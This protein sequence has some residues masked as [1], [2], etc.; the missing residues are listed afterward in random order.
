MT[1]RVRLAGAI[2]LAVAAFAAEPAAAAQNLG[3]PIELGPVGT[4]ELVV[5]DLDDDGA[6]DV[7]HAGDPLTTWYGDGAGA[8]AEETHDLD[9]GLYL[10][11]T[12]ADL[13]EDGFGD[14]LTTQIL[15]SGTP[16]TN[17]FKLLSDGA[18]GLEAGMSIPGTARMLNLATG[19]F[20]GDGHTDVAGPTMAGGPI[21]VLLGDGAGGFDAGADYASVKPAGGIAAADLDGNGRDDLIMAQPDGVAVLRAR[22]GPLA[23]RPSGGLDLFLP[24]VL[25]S[26]AG[27]RQLALGDFDADGKLD[28]AATAFNGLYLLF[29]DGLGGLA[30]GQA[31]PVGFIGTVS[32]VATGDFG[33]DGSSDLAVVGDGSDLPEESPAVVSLILGRADRQP[34]SAGVYDAGLDGGGTA[35]LA[36]GDLDEDGEEDVVVS[37]SQGTNI[38]YG[39]PIRMTPGLTLFEDT[40]VDAISPVYTVT[41]SNRDDTAHAIAGVGIDGDDAGQF[42]IASETCTGQTLAPGASC[43]IGVRFTPDAPVDA[44]AAL[45]VDSDAP[46]PHVALLAG[47]AFEAPALDVTP[48]SLSFGTVSPGAV[49]A[50]RTVTATNEGD[51]E[52]VIT[53]GGLFGS[54]YFVMADQDCYPVVLEPGDSCSVTLRFRPGDFGPAAGSLRFTGTAANTPITVP[55]SGSTPSRPPNGG[56]IVTP[57]ELDFGRVALGAGV[58]RDVVL[59]NGGVA[60]LTLG[61]LMVEPYFSGFSAQQAGCNAFVVGLSPSC[62]VTVRFAPSHEGGHQANVFFRSPG[63][64]QVGRFTVKGIGFAPA[65]PPPVQEKQPLAARVRAGIAGWRDRGVEG[66]VKRGLRLTKVSVVLPGSATLELSARR[67]GKTIVVAKG[68]HRYKAAGKADIVAKATKRGRTL[69][70]G[71]DQMRLSVKLRFRSKAG[72]VTAVTTTFVLRRLTR[73]ASFATCSA[74]PARNLPSASPHPRS[75]CSP[76]A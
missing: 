14:L 35:F 31:V 6:L 70:R 15:T 75:A 71:A 5:A 22:T 9:L 11:L 16:T 58:T 26:A 32:M 65:K 24:E 33:G 44:L 10:T 17:V 42:A 52:L 63:G 64:P 20:D 54:D 59:R 62:R 69:L 7:A 45:I 49:S 67:A 76:S 51:I 21:R 57:A 60:S 4:G 30:A 25:A 55:L 23:T 2:A 66:L 41:A 48:S 1:R 37:A 39:D 12:S 40:R 72:K 18:G 61:E 34:V 19:D 46:S 47:S 53:G 73:R 43:S 28:V 56:L 74:S 29:G 50:E 3:F 36:T 13:D 27:V 8:F 68:A 38:L